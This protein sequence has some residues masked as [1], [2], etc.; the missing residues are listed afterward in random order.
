MPSASCHCGAIS[1][2]VPSRPEYLVDY[3]CSICRRYG[4]LWAFYE[5]A[6]VKLVGHPESTTAYIWGQRSIQTMH[7]K[8]CGCVTH[9]EPIT[10]EAGTKFGI[11]MRNFQPAVTAG[12]RIRKFDGAESWAYVE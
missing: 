5:S 2:T 9:W 12:V 7:C 8:I 11:N 6:T 4:A 3:N 10:S 1:L